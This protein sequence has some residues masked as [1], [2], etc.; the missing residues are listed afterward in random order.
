MIGLRLIADLVVY[1]SSIDL[2]HSR[3]ADGARESVHAPLAH[4]WSG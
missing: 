2:F 1:G 3:F 4:E